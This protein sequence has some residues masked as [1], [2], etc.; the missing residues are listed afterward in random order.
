MTDNDLLH[1]LA[2][3]IVEALEVGTGKHE[4]DVIDEIFKAF[5]VSF[6]DIVSAVPASMPGRAERLRK[7]AADRLADAAPTPEALISEVVR[8]GGRFIAMLDE[9]YRRLARHAATETGTAETF[10]LQ[11]AGVDEE[12][13][14][15]SEAFI[16]RVRDI[17]RV[18]RTVEI[19]KV[20]EAAIGSFMGWDGGELYGTWPVQT[21]AAGRLADAVLNLTWITP[22]VSQDASLSAARA[23]LGPAFDAAR[24]SA[25]RLVA[26]AEQLVRAYVAHADLLSGADAETAA[27]LLFSNE[28]A[29]WFMGYAAAELERF[30]TE[31]VLAQAAQPEYVTGMNETSEV[32]LSDDLK[33][34]VLPMRTRSYRHSTGLSALAGFVAMYRLGFWPTRRRTP[35]MDR[36]SGDPS[37][38]GSWLDWVSISCDQAA[39]WL[40]ND[41]FV[42]T[43]SVDVTELLE[44]L[45]EFLNLPLWRQRHLLYEVWVLCATFD[46]CEQDGWAVELRGLTRADRTWILK[47]GPAND[48]VATLNHT[49]YPAT[50]LDVW[51]EP[52]RTVATGLLT[53]DVAIS[54]PRPY[55]R[56][57]LVVEAKD[58]QKM[59]LGRGHA[60]QGADPSAPEQR[61]ALGV[62]ERYA[63]GLRP[64]A[65]W[66]CNHCDFRQ[67]TESANNHGDTWTRIYVAAQFRPGNVPA[68]F[69]DSVRAALAPP[70]NPAGIQ[71]A[72]A[73][74]GLVLVVDVTSSMSRFLANAYT[75]LRETPAS[76]FFQEF[77]AVLY[78]DHGR[79]EPFLVRKVGPF[80]D[81]PSL[82]DSAAAL[83]NGRGGDAD[84]ALEDAMQRC[85]EL[86]DDIGPQHLLVLT[87][88]P[89]HPASDCPYGI[90]F[91]A[92]TRALLES[93][94]SLHV[95]SDW[96]SSH[97]DTWTAFQ[98]L[99]RFRL[100]PLREILSQI[101]ATVTGP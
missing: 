6:S 41:V 97:D 100:A 98:D 53:P 87:D 59:S 68:I 22:L 56:D 39:A 69:A 20:D 78:S 96:L 35:I 15:I 65:T 71:D 47:L 64:S 5:G 61:T 44:T 19:G 77:R 62:A 14:T 81:L 16:E 40:V 67:E 90:S 12:R 21:A 23:E 42:A 18:L 73:D 30:R 94:S 82:L 10:R 70:S 3:L 8:C 89:P 37:A 63:A 24:A 92:E 60:Q 48:P 54:T 101:G 86:T 80:S 91:E 43:R 75:A 4:P 76:A 74:S 66:V 1:S 83:P 88:A 93:G 11:R 57:L 9:V 55:V 72:S 46:A 95:A 99:P 52:S 84:E 34:V 27:A 33:P 17:E 32:G 28:P 31:R 2:E 85:R 29:D 45:Q 7:R 58:R 49:T 13:L 51:R 25:G 38:L 36:L 26:A 79:D 50:S